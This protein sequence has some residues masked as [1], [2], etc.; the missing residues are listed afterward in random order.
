MRGSSAVALDTLV[1]EV[2][3]AVHDGYD[4]FVTIW[5]TLEH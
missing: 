5:M 1:R 2:G 4:Q 3:V